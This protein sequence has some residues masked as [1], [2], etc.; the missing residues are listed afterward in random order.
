MRNPE[1]WEKEWRKTIT[2]SKFPPRVARDLGI[3]SPETLSNEP[4][5]ESMFIWGNSATG[6][7]LL[8][9]N[10]LLQHEK[11]CFVNETP[12][13]SV[14][15]SFPDML[16]DIRKTYSQRKEITEDVVISKY[17]D[18][19]FLVIDDFL[20]S[21]LTDWVYA[22]LYRVI[23]H[24]YEYLLTTVITSNPDLAEIEKILNDQR[25]TSRINRSYDI[26][27]KIKTWDG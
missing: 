1:T 18:C 11:H 20:T 26:V 8:A 17:L 5:S 23:N 10:L 3:Y 9:A 15:V 19:D 21:K 22:I 24:R 14:F 25:I 12:T 27:E 13:N 4:V 2:Q 16:A 7:T 6:K